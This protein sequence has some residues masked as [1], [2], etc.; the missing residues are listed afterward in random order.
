MTYAAQ[1]VTTLS[2][3]ATHAHE[4]KFLRKAAAQKRLFRDIVSLPLRMGGELFRAFAEYIVVGDDQHPEMVGN[5]EV[6]F[7]SYDNRLKLGGIKVV[8]DGL[9]QGKTAFWTEPLLTPGPAGEKN[10]RGAPLLPPETLNQTLATR[11]FC[12]QASGGI[13][14]CP[15]SK[16]RGLVEGASASALRRLG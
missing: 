8:V 1:G 16:S 14:R 11:H 2:E 7:G 15:L 3:G 5:P 9:P 6:E 4:L 10:W 13:L 12:K